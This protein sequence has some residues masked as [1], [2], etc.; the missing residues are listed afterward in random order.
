M[1]TKELHDGT[2]L[3]LHC[4]GGKTTPVIK[5]PRTIDT[6]THTHTHTHTSTTIELLKSG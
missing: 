5:L 1:A 2:V 4:D 6:R 3:H